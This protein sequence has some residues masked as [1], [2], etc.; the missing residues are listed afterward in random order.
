M[1]DE[2][3]DELKSLYDYVKNRY[4][5][6]LPD[7]I[8]DMMYHKVICSILNRLLAREEDNNAKL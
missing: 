8:S 4:M 1:S 7:L 6:E 5:D 3:R 2:V